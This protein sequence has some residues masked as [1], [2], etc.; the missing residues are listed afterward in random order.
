MMSKLPIFSMIFGAYG[1]VF[2]NTGTLVRA[3]MLPTLALLV[4][5]AIQNAMTT[6][7]FK[8]VLFWI[9]AMPFAT[10]IA[11]ACHRVVQVGPDSLNNP[12]SVYW[13]KRETAYFINLIIL[14]VVLLL[15]SWIFGVIFLMSPETPFGISTPWLGLVLTYI[16]V[17]YFQG[18]FCMVLPVSAVGKN[19]FLSGSWY[20][21]AGNGPRMT[22]I[23]L[24][25][26]AVMFAI[27]SML[28]PVLVSLPDVAN[29]LINLLVYVV[30]F[31]VEVAAI[32]L[33][34]QFLRDSANSSN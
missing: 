20:L 11:V 24:I 34:Y 7:F 16:A 3:F 25:P 30:S 21:T 31:A 6:G 1:A 14:S 28:R 12:W 8:T 22:V 4:L 27:T 9:I 23:L 15:G 13:T 29:L 33:C 17:A 19:M 32:S 5:S 26:L 10:L 2:R 18:R